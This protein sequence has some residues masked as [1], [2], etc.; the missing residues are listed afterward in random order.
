MLFV[1]YAASDK[2]P[3]FTGKYLTGLEPLAGLTRNCDFNEPD[4]IA[5]TFGKITE[6]QQQ[7][8]FNPLIRTLACGL[9][10]IPSAKHIP[11]ALDYLAG[12]NAVGL[13]SHFDEFRPTLTELMGIDGLGEAQLTEVS[14]VSRIAT[15]LRKLDSVRRLLAFDAELYARASDAIL[16]GLSRR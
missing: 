4:T 12:M 16:Q 1:R 3:S 11:I 6:S 15:D 5:A 10:E 2:S 9:D 14:F 13:F 7:I 8:L